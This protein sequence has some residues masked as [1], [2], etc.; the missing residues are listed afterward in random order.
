MQFSNKVHKFH[1]VFKHPA[2]DTLA[3]NLD[4]T[5]IKA[6]IQYMAEELDEL[7]QSAGLN[8]VDIV[9]EMQ[10]L[11]KFKP[12]VD[13]HKNVNGAIDA[14]VDLAYFL[15]GTNVALGIP[16]PLFNQVF[17]AVHK[18]NMDK[19]CLPDNLAATLE[20]YRQR[21]IP[22]LVE[23]TFDNKGFII[24]GSDNNKVLKPYGYLPSDVDEIVANYISNIPEISNG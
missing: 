13:N 17:E 1:K 21:N 11:N 6:R 3:V 7:A 16:E 19:V 15:F 5:L 4:P 9:S 2:P 24:T 14:L 20:M 12:L 18:A 23:A 22:V 10:T 8:L